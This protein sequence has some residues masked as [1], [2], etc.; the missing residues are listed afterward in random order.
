[1]FRKDGGDISDGND[2]GSYFSHS[3]SIDKVQSTIKEER[4][5]SLGVLEEK[6]NSLSAEYKFNLVNCSRVSSFNNK[7]NTIPYNTYEV[8]RRSSSK[9]IGGYGGYGSKEKNYKNLCGMSGI[10]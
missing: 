4:L 6:K 8:D 1:L 10:K 7:F 9:K 2:S 5:K 3:F